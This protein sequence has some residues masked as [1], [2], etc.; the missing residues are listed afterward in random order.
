MLKLAANG[1]ISGSQNLCFPKLSERL[2]AFT[3]TIGCPQ[4]DQPNAYHEHLLVGRNPKE[5]IQGAGFKRS[6]P[7]KFE[8]QRR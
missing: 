8:S 2:N 3:P 1:D 4:D 7:L 5:P 6:G